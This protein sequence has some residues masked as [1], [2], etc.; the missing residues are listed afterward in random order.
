MTMWF[1]TAAV[2]FTVA[3]LFLAPAVPS[4]P[5]APA[6][7]EPRY[8]TATT[9]NTTVVVTEIKEVPAGSPLSGYHLMVRPESGKGESETMDVY[10]APVDFV[11]DFDCH[12][13]KGDR[14]QV[15]GSKVKTGAG[16]TVLARE[17]RAGSN[18]MYLRDEAGTPYWKTGKT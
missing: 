2:F 18:T 15:I 5:K 14:I 13:A 9:I 12:L 6:E 3:P 16:H 8:D 10:L 17:V 11:K 1:R 7:P 4:D